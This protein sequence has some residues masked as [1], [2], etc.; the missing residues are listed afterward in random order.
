MLAFDETAEPI[1]DSEY[2][3]SLD[4]WL[5]H[6][7]WYRTSCPH[8]GRLVK[9]RLGN[10]AFIGHVQQF[11][12]SRAVTTFRLIR[13]RVVYSGTHGGDWIASADSVRLLTEAQN[14]RET[15]TDQMIAQFAADL[16]ELSEA[17]I[18]TGNPLV[19]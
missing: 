7:G 6:D 12:E 3:I 18:A 9:K 10:V 14:L 1:L 2:E 13:E 4:Q 17:S 16:I 15:A 19:F 11:V 5:L 8:S